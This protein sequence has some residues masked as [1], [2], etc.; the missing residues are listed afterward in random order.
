[1]RAE[2][3]RLLKEVKPDEVVLAVSQANL[4]ALAAIL[5]VCN[6]Q[7]V[8]W[9]FVPSLDQL[10]FGN[11]RTHLIA[12]VPLISLKQANLSGFNFIVKRLIDM[13]LAAV[14]LMLAA[15]LMA[16][17]WI[18]VRLT[19]PGPAIFVQQRIGRNRCV[20]DCYKFRTM[21]V[22]NDQNTH[23]EYAKQWIAN[24]A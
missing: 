12:G 17:I 9:H 21:T 11:S 22:R 7:H 3:E 10:V 24:Q 18:L 4:E 1:L 20:F 2:V 6:E 13:S 23:K 15:P 14:M 5:N 19:S 8:P 16:V